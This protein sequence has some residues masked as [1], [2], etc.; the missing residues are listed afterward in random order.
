MNRL[1]PIALAVFAIATSFQACAYDTQLDS[2]TIREAYFLGRKSDQ[3]TIGFL[4][5]Y[6]KSLPMPERGPYISQIALYTPYAQIVLNSWR[7]TLGYSSQQAEQDYETAGDIVRI[8]VQID[9]TPT[10]TAI[11]KSNSTDERTK[12]NGYVF[13][14]EDFWCDFQVSLLQADKQVKP[15]RGKGIPIYDD[16]GFSGAEIWLEFNTKD[17]KSEEAIVQVTSPE[18][19]LAA[20]KFDLSRLR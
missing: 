5:P 15:L 14:S 16:G 1:T 12:T 19:Q 17:V 13:R 18:G 8:R 6:F 2:E 7:H 3:Q 10:Y 9:F 11:L 20:A 4:K